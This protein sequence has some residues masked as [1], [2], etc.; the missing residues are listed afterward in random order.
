MSVAIDTTAPVGARMTR[1]YPGGPPPTG[2]RPRPLLDGNGTV[3]AMSDDI[4]IDQ[5]RSR[6]LAIGCAWLFLALPGVFGVIV[7]I[8]SGGNSAVG[9]ILTSTY[10][11]GTV[12]L[13]YLFVRASNLAVTPMESRSGWIGWRRTD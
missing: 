1:F 12:Y 6:R 13:L 4:R 11:L 3:S 5:L 8:A 9:W 7:L 2:V 10:A